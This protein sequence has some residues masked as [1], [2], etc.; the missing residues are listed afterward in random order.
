MA[1]RV[2]IFG[3]DDFELTPSG[4]VK[5]GSRSV[6]FSVQLRG[7]RLSRLLR[8][9]PKQRNLTLR[10]TLK[11]QF[12]KLAR[13]FPAANLRSRDERTGSWTL[14]GSLPARSIVAFASQREVQDL[15]VDSIDGQKRLTRRATLGWFC[16]WGIVAIQIE[17]RTKGRVDIE[18]RFVLVKAYDATDACRRLRRKWLRYAKPYLNPYGYLVRWQLV[19]VR[20]VYF[21]MQDN[22]DP[23]GT[24]VYSRLRTEKMKPEYR[25]SPRL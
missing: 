23:R 18:D 7:Q 20:D 13:R 19:S 15:T 22:I 24:E 12:R 17:G 21:V 5:L 8:L 10:D 9:Q 14:D 6:K 25:W 4:L 11:Q 16:V 2:R 1:K 3:L